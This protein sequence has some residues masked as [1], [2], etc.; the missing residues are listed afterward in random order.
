MYAD[1]FGPIN[2]TMFHLLTD[3][4]AKWIDVHSVTQTISQ[5]TITNTDS[6]FATFSIPETIRADNCSPFAGAE[7]SKFVGNNARRHIKTAPYHRASYGLEERAV[8]TV[9]Q[10][11]LKHRVRTLPKKLDHFLS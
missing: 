10:G 1:D 2:G 7:V 11:R 3:A 4:H 9:K 5:N 6:S 8:Q